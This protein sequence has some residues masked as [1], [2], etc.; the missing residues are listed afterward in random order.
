MFPEREVKRVIACD[1]A[2]YPG[3]QSQPEFRT[4]QQEMAT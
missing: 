3:R 2:D 1:D 4:V